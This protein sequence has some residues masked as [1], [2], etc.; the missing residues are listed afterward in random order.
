VV[1]GG[2]G[3]RNKRKHERQKERR[4][5]KM[6]GARQQT[7][8]GARELQEIKIHKSEFNEI[9]IHKSEFKKL[10]EASSRNLQ[11][12][13]CYMRIYKRQQ[14]R[15]NLNF[16]KGGGGVGKRKKKTRGS[17]TAKAGEKKEDAHTCVCVAWTSHVG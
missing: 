4:Q 2:R 5:Q 13:N 9:K 14:P 6:L 12:L 10:A 7:M 16:M 15:A 3:Q 1:G 11:N 17:D 8:L